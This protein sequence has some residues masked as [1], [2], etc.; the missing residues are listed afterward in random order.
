VSFSETCA[1]RRSSVVVTMLPEE[2]AHSSQDREWNHDR[3]E[4]DEC[5]CLIAGSRNEHLTL[6]AQL[7]LPEH[8][9]LEAEPANA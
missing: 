7:P 3:P 5:R 9:A 8:A 1:R 4:N 6:V 2:P